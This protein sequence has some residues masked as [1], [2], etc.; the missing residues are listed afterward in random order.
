MAKQTGLGWTTLSVDDSGGTPVA[1]KN[2]VTNFQF[3]TPRGVQDASGIDV[4]GYERLLLRADFTITINAVFNT[5]VGHTVFK[6]VPSTSVQRTTTLV[7]SSQ[8]LAPE[9]LYTDYNLTM[10]ASGELTYS[11]PGVLTGGSAPTWA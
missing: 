11:A 5:A 9:V 8:T 1:I 4:L 7:I 2:D 10:A 6:T 3:A